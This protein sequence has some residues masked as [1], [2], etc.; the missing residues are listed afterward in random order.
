MKQRGLSRSMCRGLFALK[1]SVGRRCHA[2]RSMMQSCSADE[3][4]TNRTHD[5]VVAALRA[6]RIRLESCIGAL[7]K[8]SHVRYKSIV[9][10]LLPQSVQLRLKILHA[11]RQLRVLRNKGFI[12]RAESVRLGNQV[13][14]LESE[15]LRLFPGKLNPLILNAAGKHIAEVTCECLE[16]GSNSLANV[17]AHAPCANERREK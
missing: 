17:R 10:K 13:V 7:P 1:F 3:K 2:I 4:A 16:H 14:E 15:I 12:L 9:C 8:D 6:I 11:E 5:R